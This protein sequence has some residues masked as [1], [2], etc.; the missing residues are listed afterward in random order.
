MIETDLLLLYSEI[1]ALHIIRHVLTWES[2]WTHTTAGVNYK[3][4]NSYLCPSQNS[5]L[6]IEINQNV[7]REKWN[8]VLRLEVCQMNMNKSENRL[9]SWLSVCPNM[10]TVVKSHLDLMSNSVTQCFSIISR[11][12]TFIFRLTRASQCT[13]FVYLHTIYKSIFRGETARW[14]F[15][16]IYKK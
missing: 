10:T 2:Q 13:S 12:N 15:V 11:W 16:C 6:V 5:Q 7:G 9:F 3:R 4:T 14:S 8:N 1:S